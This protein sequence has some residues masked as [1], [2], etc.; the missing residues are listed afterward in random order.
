MIEVG[1]RIPSV[2]FRRML[3]D[4]SIVDL[5]TAE[6]FKGK[7]MILFGLPGAFTPTCSKEHL[8]SYVARAHDLRAKGI[9]GVVCMA[10]NDHW[11]MRAWADEHGA[12]GKVDMLA[13]GNGELT[14]ALGLEVDLGGAKLGPRCRRFVAVLDDGVFTKIE[15]EPGKGIEV[16]GA[17]ACLSG[18]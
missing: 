1:Q 6:I 17:D 2:K 9:D 5:D 4:G 11:V 18:L 15:V 14:R 7:K 12:E 8:P 16:T 13:D 10:T 3:V